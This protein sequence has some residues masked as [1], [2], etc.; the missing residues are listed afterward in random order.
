MS[1]NHD[2]DEIL[3]PSLDL[4]GSVSYGSSPLLD[5][6]GSH[7]EADPDIPMSQRYDY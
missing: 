1:S 2:L 5:D 4:T 7:S 3:D 6:Q